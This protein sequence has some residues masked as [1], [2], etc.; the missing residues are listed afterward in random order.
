MTT[1][2]IEYALSFG[3]EK[4]DGLWKV[5]LLHP[6]DANKTIPV[7]L[8]MDA[9]DSRIGQEVNK[10][11]VAKPGVRLVEVMKWLYDRITRYPYY[12]PKEGT[13]V[14]KFG[15]DFE[16]TLIKN[17][18]SASNVEI[19]Q[20]AYDILKAEL[21]IQP[22]DPANTNDVDIQFETVPGSGALVKI[23][24]TLSYPQPVSELVIAPFTKYPMELAALIYEEDIKT[25]HAK[26]EIIL[27]K[28]ATAKKRFEQTTRSIR[29]Q[30]P[31]VIAKRFTII[32][33][34]Q[35][36]EKNTY[37]VNEDAVNKKELW[38][39]VSQREAEVTL[40]ANDGLETVSSQELDKWSG[41]DIYLQALDKHKKDLAA[42]EKEYEIYIQKKTERE[43][44]LLEKDKEEKRF[45]QAT[46]AYREE[47]NRALSSYNTRV[48]KYNQDLNNYNASYQKYERDL[49]LYNKY[50]RDYGEWKSKW[51]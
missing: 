36:A 51:G 24:V 47:Y 20:V 49:S 39:T 44:K 43:A 42:W 30:F 9:T 28:E 50:L 17:N 27:P 1:T 22:K 21:R 8:P 5:Q 15:Y 13:Y 29:L 34:Q 2:Y 35:N 18:T 26:K 14:D 19:T 7:Y 16:A 41:W 40:D 4:A 37:V 38:D 6:Y 25:F 31:A 32:L 48:A 45:Q 46:S 10:I 3:V 11:M 23:L 33:R 12:W